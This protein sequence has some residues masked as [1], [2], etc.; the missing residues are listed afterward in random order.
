MSDEIHRLSDELAHDPSSLAFLRLAELLRR[1]GDLAAAER[2]ARRGR[3]RNPGLAAA[4]DLALLGY[5]VTIFEAADEPGGMMRYGIPEYRLPRSLLRAEID[6]ILALGVTLRLQTP[7]TP[8]FDLTALR[9]AGFDAVF[10]AVGV[11]RGATC[12]L[13]ASSSMAWS[14]RWITC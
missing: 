5:R 12:R 6:R 10:L 14:R 8:D 1:G 7:L 2:V 3:D 11:S 13:P 4:H 9:R